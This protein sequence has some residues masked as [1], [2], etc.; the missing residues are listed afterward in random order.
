M[1]QSPARCTVA[2]FTAD[3]YDST[4]SSS[5]AVDVLAS[6][7]VSSSVDDSLLSAVTADN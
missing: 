1:T 4:D 6:L 5:S 3:A 7:V 2:R